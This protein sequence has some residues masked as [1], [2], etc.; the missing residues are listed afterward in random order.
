MEEI[1]VVRVSGDTF[2][3]TVNDEGSSTTHEVTCSEA[4]RA[5]LADEA[6][7]EALIE[8]S[9]RFLLEREPK[10]SILRK[11]EITVIGRYFPEYQD[12]IR[13]RLP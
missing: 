9:F 4:T 8:E 6:S 10:E 3:V 2:R 11:F 1:E 5:R 12:E 7:A 13:A